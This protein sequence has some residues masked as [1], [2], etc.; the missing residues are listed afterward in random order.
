MFDWTN[1]ERLGTKGGKKGGLSRSPAKRRAA[2]RNGQ[3]GGRK[4]KRNLGEVLL[5]QKLTSNQ[6]H[7]VALAF[8]DLTLEERR[9]VKLYFYGNPLYTEWPKYVFDIP[10]ETDFLRRSLPQPRGSMR[11]IL[12]KFRLMARRRFAEP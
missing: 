10:K 5:R 4:R 1:A 11:F 8:L 2:K 3:L 9:L 7:K 12:K 6:L